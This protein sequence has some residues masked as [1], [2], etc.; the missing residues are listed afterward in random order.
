MI[1]NAIFVVYAISIFLALVLIIVWIML[2]FYVVKMNDRL[3]RIEDI[4]EEG[5]KQFYQIRMAQHRNK[6]SIRSAE[7][8]EKRKQPGT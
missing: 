2:P 7:G 1:G 8:K 3:K 6:K 5:L 4:L